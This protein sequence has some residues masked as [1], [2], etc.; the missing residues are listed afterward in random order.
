MLPLGRL[1]ATAGPIALSA[2]ASGLAWL[3]AHDLVGHPAPLFAPVAAYTVVGLTIGRHA[4]RALELTIGQA[5]GILIADVVVSLLG[6]GAAQVGLVVGTSMT[7]ALFVGRGVLLAQQ[8]ALS[9]VVVAGLQLPGS[10]L[11][12]ARYV[13]VL[14]G[15]VVSITLKLLLFPNDPRAIGPDRAKPLLDGLAGTLDDVAAAL[16]TM[17]SAAADDALARARSL[18]ELRQHFAE[19]VEAGSEA[20]RLSPRRR[21]SRGVVAS[22][23]QIAQQLDLAVRNTRVLARRARRAVERHEVVP[24]ELVD[25]VRALS[26]AVRDFDLQA[27]KPEHVTAVDRLIDAATLANAS[28]HVDRTLSVT[29]LIAQVRSLVQDLLSCAGLDEAAAVRAI[30]AA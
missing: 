9:A 4:G 27:S 28:L 1:R 15:G 26:S 30:D 22:Q 21:R 12:G 24:N 29:V 13:D 5:L 19:A 17:D 18:D 8:A 10:G 3:I 25:A 20:A 16:T 6:T 14:I 23:L 7:I 2:L 11:S